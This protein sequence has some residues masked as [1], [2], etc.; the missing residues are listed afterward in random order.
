MF[1]VPIHNGLGF[2]EFFEQ[3]TRYFSCTKVEILSYFYYFSNLKGSFIETGG[4]IKAYTPI[5]CRTIQFKDANTRAN[6]A[7]FINEI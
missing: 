7:K 6:L 5:W 1:L 4:K 3:M 2:L